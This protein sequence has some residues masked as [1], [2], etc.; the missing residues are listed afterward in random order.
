MTSEKTTSVVDT[1]GNI[2]TVITI[3]TGKKELII[4]Q[5]FLEDL[6]TNNFLAVRTRSEKVIRVIPIYDKNGEVLLR[7][8]L[9]SE[10]TSSLTKFAM[11]SLASILPAFSV[12]WTT[13][14]CSPANKE[15][16]E[17]GLV[18]D[19]CMWEGILQGPEN[20]MSIDEIKD[21][22][23]KFHPGGSDMESQLKKL[24]AE[25]ELSDDR[26]MVSRIN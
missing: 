12:K 4:P 11:Y 8:K 19:A 6:A 25:V 24:D 17:Y 20:D 21:Q 5:P 3:E 22:I 18:N 23:V 1:P 26:V 13:G 14:I 9:Y 15:Q 7:I 10:G 2:A 16:E